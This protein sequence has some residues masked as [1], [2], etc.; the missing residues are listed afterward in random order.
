MKKKPT[1]KR[2]TV[3]L[4]GRDYEKLS[5]LARKQRTTRP[6]MARRLLKAQ[7]EAVEIEKKERQA[8]NQLGLFDS[9]QI[10]I[11]NCTSKASE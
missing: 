10:D 7:L 4:S 11:F 2:V 6:I 1:K 3:L 8:R 9:L 5:L